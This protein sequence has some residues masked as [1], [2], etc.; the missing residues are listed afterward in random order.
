MVEHCGRS[1]CVALNLQVT[2]DFAPA[3]GVR[4]GALEEVL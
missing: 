1:G 2:A 4:N 3:S